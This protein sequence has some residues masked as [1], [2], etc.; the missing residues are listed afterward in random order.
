MAKIEM[1]LSE[2]QEIQKVNRLLEES[3]EKERQ[4][5]E[6]VDKLKQEKIDILKNNEK[7]VTI[8]E[9]V[10]RV[11]TIRTLQDPSLIMRNL[12]SIMSRS[13]LG[14]MG[15]D[16]Q[17]NPYIH[18]VAEAFFKIER[19][20]LYSQEK[21]VTRVGFDEVKE[22]AKK[23]FLKT[24][25]EDYEMK[26]KAIRDEVK[27]LKEQAKENDGLSQANSMLIKENER[28][29]NNYKFY[30]DVSESH[31][32]GLDKISN[33]LKDKF[34]FFNSRI[35]RGLISK[36]LKETKRAHQELCENRK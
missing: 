33:I 34:T 25:E 24:L 2:Y 15:Y 16:Y 8:V 35:K 19:S 32:K 27:R 21:S 12:Q 11:D 26:E 10:D 20:D 6:E 17:G 28:L 31:A 1:D 9:R 5:A 23:E 4:L 7:T 22:E 18:Q 30:R 36:A 14:S 3:L 13:D 29:V